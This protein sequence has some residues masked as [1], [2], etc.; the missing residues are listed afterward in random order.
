MR[1]MLIKWSAIA[2]IVI[3]VTFGCTTALQP[4][5]QQTT[6][7]SVATN[8]DGFAVVDSTF[9]DAPVSPGGLGVG[10]G[11]AG[12]AEEEEGGEATRSF[13]TAFQIDPD[14]EDSAGPK[15][16]RSGD[17]DQ[18]GMLDLVTAWNQSQPIQLH[19]QRRD[20]AGNVTFRTI[21]LGGTSP[22]AIMADIELGQIND[23]GWLDIVV[24]SKATGA[25]TL[26]PTNPPTEI[27][28][29]EGEIVVLFSPGSAA[30]IPDGDQ[31]TQM[32]LVNPFVR[33]RRGTTGE[34]W[35]HDQFPG[36]ED[37]PF[38]DGQTHPELNGFTALAVG[39]IDGVPGDE[40]VVALNTGEC[41]DLGQQPAITTVDLWLNPGP[42]LSE[43]PNQW[44]A[45]FFNSDPDVD[46]ACPGTHLPHPPGTPGQAYSSFLRVPISLVV[47]APQIRDVELLDVDSDGD[48]DVITAVSNGIS[49]NVRWQ[50]NPLIANRPGGPSGLTAVENGFSDGW[51]FM[52]SDWESRPIGQV[53]TGAD[54]VTLA[55]MDGD[56]STDVV[57][58]S[59]AGVVQWFR[60]P[61]TIVRE[62]E[63]PP[64]DAVPDRFNF[65]WAVYTLTEFGENQ[66][67]EG[68]GVGDLTGDG[69]VELVVAAQGAAFWYDG[70]AGASVFD[71]WAPNTIIQDSPA[72]ATG[73]TAAGAAGSTVS[74]GGA[75][76]TP[77]ANTPAPGT[78]FGVQSTDVS[79]VI[80]N[81]LVIDL[82]ADGRMDIVGTLDRRSGP[83]LSDDRLVWYRN[84]RTEDT[85][86]P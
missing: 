31:W 84:T 5:G 64:S 49:R 63:F 74:S 77:A 11:S 42:G 34:L 37:V 62:P 43:L 6:Q 82:D 73:G 52:A 85:P 16:I 35:I 26:C 80:N 30:L 69:Q 2:A 71:P 20:A 65:P 70:N 67:P 40:I 1:R 75:S 59:S 41:A 28:S 66:Q 24:L 33:C 83:G 48:L 22:L 56:G 46:A 19:L 58:R 17:V 55:D 68:V 44:G 18:D 81:L 61:N 53:D 32:I 9:S 12:A 51:R 7:T 54:D 14:A 57:V 79:T 27:S 15:F 25:V 23:D 76:T 13:F 29:L 78:G 3:I 39:N 50:R 60:H 10:A 47:E 38:V 36:V 21:N 86:A 72:D 45:P 8:T 4:S